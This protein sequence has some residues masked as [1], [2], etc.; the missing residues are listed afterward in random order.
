MAVRMVW[1]RLAVGRFWVTDAKRAFNLILSGPARELFG[2]YTHICARAWELW[3]IHSRI[4]A[5]DV[6]ILLRVVDHALTSIL[7][8]RHK[9]G[10]GAS[11]TFPRLWAWWD[12]RSFVHQVKVLL[13]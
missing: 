10:C 12:E 3:V 6:A 9:S 11:V 4:V 2:H 1:I 7:V 8:P 5:P 13:D